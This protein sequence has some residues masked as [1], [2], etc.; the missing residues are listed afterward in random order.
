M[1]SVP[2]YGAWKKGDEA[3]TGYNKTIGG[4]KRSTEYEYHE[5][6]EIDKI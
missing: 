2:K 1:K 4:H 3:H 6:G 5:E